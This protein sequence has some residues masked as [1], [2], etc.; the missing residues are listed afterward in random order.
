LRKHA[1]RLGERERVCYVMRAGHVDGIQICLR[2]DRNPQRMR[3]RIGAEISTLGRM[4]DVPDRDVF[5]R[6]LFD[7][8]LMM[9]GGTIFSLIWLNGL[10]R[11]L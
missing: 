8:G 6:A 2:G 10:E 4:D 1:L 5:N 7:H 3:E 9:F 11:Q